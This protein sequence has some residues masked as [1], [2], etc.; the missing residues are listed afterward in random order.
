[1]TD[2]EWTAV[3]QLLPMPGWLRGRGGWPEGYC[4]RVMLDQC[5]VVKGELAVS[6]AK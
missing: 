2:V 5:H 3:R 1:M 6:R 4:H